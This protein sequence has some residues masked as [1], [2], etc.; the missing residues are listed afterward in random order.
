V[1]SDKMVWP[2]KLYGGVRIVDQP[3]PANVRVMDLK[4]MP[5]VLRMQSNG[6]LINKP[7]F[8]EFSKYL[9]GECERLTDKV[10]SVSG[11]RINPGSPDQIHELLFQ[12][13]GLQ[14][15]SHF[16]LTESGKRYTV[17][18][19]ALSSIKNLHPVIPVIQDYTECHKIKTSYA[20]VLP[21]IASK[22][23]GRVYS[24]FRITRQVGG[25]I[26]S[27]DPNLMAQPTRSDLGKR[28]RNGFIPRPGWK[29]WT[30]DQSQI[31]MRIAAHISGC[32]SM[33]D[34]FLRG[35]DVHIE[36]AARIFF[37]GL[38]D[39]IAKCTGGKKEVKAMAA[40]AGM[41]D[42]RHRYP[43]KRIGFG[44]LFGITGQGLQDQIFV[45]DDPTWSDTDRAAFR[46]E[47]PVERCD[48]TIHGWYQ[49][50][51][52]IYQSIISEHAKARR[53]GMV[54]CLFGR[55]RWI[56][57]VRSV[58]KRIIEAGLRQAYS[59]RVS[60]TAQGTMKLTMA[61]IMDKLILGKYKGVV[62]PLIQIHDE[63]LGESREDV[64]EEFLYDAI[65]IA[66]NCINLD[67]PIEVGSD[68]GGSWGE[69]S[70]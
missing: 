62:E 3:S 26:S 55:I 27:S 12:K 60:A 22:E 67:V 21:V 45:A 8:N 50:Y 9:A 70:K 19:E 16:K 64:V 23:T 44:V 34:T 56:P 46:A 33:L 25:R 54:W 5:M 61:E 68:S 35:G 48:K 17:D 63:L 31:E 32:V 65:K 7:Y 10:Q 11:H 4:A 18:D 53:F 52:E 43:A 30:M 1:S 51:P 14:I 42:M 13:I 6:I 57:E 58:H 38:I 59:L 40:A 24:N 41:D 66:C 69:L 39:Q 49:Q 28:I 15:P 20:D 2:Q 29:M 37:D 36:T 47:W